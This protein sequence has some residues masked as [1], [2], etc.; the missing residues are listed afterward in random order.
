MKF[1][2]NTWIWFSPFTMAEIADTAAQMAEA[3][4]DMIEFP[5]ETIDAFDYQQAGAIAHDHGL[6]VS[7]TAAMSPERDLIHPDEAIRENGVAYIRHC[8]EALSQP[9]HR[10]GR[11]VPQPA[12]L[13]QLDVAR[14]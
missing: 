4:F 3:G 5:I 10:R 8:I 6:G 12:Q 1:G 14:D 2:A 11:A 9:Q 13:H 7:T